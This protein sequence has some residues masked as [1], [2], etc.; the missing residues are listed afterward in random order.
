M[1]KLGGIAGFMVGT[2]LGVVALLAGVVISPPDMPMPPAAEVSS[3]LPDTSEPAVPEVVADDGAPVTPP[4]M[5]ADLPPEPEMAA[6]AVPNPLPDPGAPNPVQDQDAAP[7]AEDAANVTADTAAPVT[8][9]SVPQTDTPAPGPIA[10]L[11]DR[12]QADLP[13]PDRTDRQQGLPSQPTAPRDLPLPQTPQPPAPDARSDAVA[14]PADPEPMPAPTPEA[15]PEVDLADE[16]RLPG[17]RISGLPGQSRDVPQPE[18][19]EQPTATALERN[20]SFEGG[21]AGEPMMAIILND[22]GLPTPLR[23]SLA[24]LELPITIA[25][26]PMDPSAPQAAEIY[27]AAGKDVL[28][29]ASGVPDGARATDLDVTFSAYFETLP[30]AVGILDLPQD[31]FARNAGLASAILP[32]LARD[33]HGL[34]TF[35]GG[36]SRVESIAQS[37]GVPHSEA[38]RVLDDEGQNAFTIRRYLDRA[39]FQAS[40]IGEVIVFGDATNDETM[41]ALEMWRN[42]GRADQ[43]ALV[44]ISAILLM[45]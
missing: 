15:T 40:Q 22:P 24:A 32:L 35:A 9:P 20:N 4:D 14:E 28:I 30:Q 2:A 41:E 11:S 27:R 1:V 6:P 21:V 29:L 26:N 43:V 19:P 17:T 12:G 45:R 38:F 23:R 16:P 33:G 3:A 42:D 18:S 8:A 39:V 34:V 31:G 10:A 36:L 37:A 7:S 44:P 25:L 13:A 5:A